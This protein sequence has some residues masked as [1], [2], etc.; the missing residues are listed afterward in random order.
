MN[1]YNSDMCEFILSSLLL[2]SR[3]GGRELEALNTN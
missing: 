3:G 1:L 2:L